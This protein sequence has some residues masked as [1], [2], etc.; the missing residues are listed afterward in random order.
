MKPPFDKWDLGKPASLKTV[1]AIEKAIGGPLPVSLRMA[2]LE[3]GSCDL[4]GTFKG[5]ER[6]AKVCTA[7]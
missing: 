7:I 4:T 2:L 3:I 1:S 5:Q 6:V